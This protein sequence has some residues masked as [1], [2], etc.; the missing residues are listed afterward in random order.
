[1]SEAQILVAR[2]GKVAQV[3]VIG[4]ATFK[5]SRE[6]REYGLRVIRNGVN[7]L[8]FDLS[9]CRGM[10]STFM[11]VLAM[12]GL[13]AK[14]K[15]K[16]VIV[17]AGPQQR[18]LL[19]SIGVSRLFDFSDKNMERVTW[20]N[21]VEAAAEVSDMGD[22]ADTI[23]NAHQTLMDLNPENVPKFKDVVEMLTHEVE[24]QNKNQQRQL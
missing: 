6:L 15:A 19:E 2:Q 17:N 16:L 23:L 13:E 10:D 9:Q 8:I 5:V 24:E 11:G 3:R 12:L 14:D 1:M 4:R 18:N 21:L 20:Q 22:V 7:S